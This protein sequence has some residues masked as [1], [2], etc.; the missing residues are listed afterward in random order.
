M[1]DRIQWLS[2]NGLYWWMFYRPR[3]SY[4][5]CKN[6]PFQSLKIPRERE[7]F[8]QTAESFDLHCSRLTLQFRESIEDYRCRLLVI[9][10][11]PTEDQMALSPFDYSRNWSKSII[12][13]LK[14]LQT[15]LVRKWIVYVYSSSIFYRIPMI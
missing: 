6:G 2:T 14:M 5:N 10:W 4:G 9:L 8:R 3:T 15:S 13:H 11:P 1:N 12:T 7:L